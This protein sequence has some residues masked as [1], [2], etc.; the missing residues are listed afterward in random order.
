MSK[1]MEALWRIWAFV[2]SIPASFVATIV[3]FVGLIWGIADVAWQLVTGGDGL[4]ESNRAAEFVIDV[5]YWPID[6]VVFAYTGDGEFAW[7][8]M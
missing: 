4:S 3:G 7:T 5:L 2:W 6:L 1:R 8:W